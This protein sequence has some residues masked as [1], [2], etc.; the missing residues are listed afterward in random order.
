MYKLFLVLLVI[1]NIS[2]ITYYSLKE[3]EVKFITEKEPCDILT[4]VEKYDKSSMIDYIVLH[5]I[6]KQEAV[7]IFDAIKSIS[8]KE[9]MPFLLLFSIVALESGFDRK[10]INGEAVGLMQINSDVWELSRAEMN[11]IY[12][13]IRRGVEIWK[14]YLLT[15][16]KKR[17][18]VDHRYAASCYVGGCDNANY[19]KRLEAKAGEFMLYSEL[20][21]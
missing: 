8:E 3:K 15:S 14:K 20:K 18:R 1:T 16:I 7:K 9:S 19:F 10:A 11:G 5:G 21:R 2:S 4:I 12:D 6:Q 17:G 13:N